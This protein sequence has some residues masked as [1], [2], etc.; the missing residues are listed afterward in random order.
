MT[1]RVGKWFML[2]CSIRGIFLK[3]PRMGQV[4][5]GRDEVAWHRSQ[6]E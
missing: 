6:R 3:M 4:W 5:V 1:I 2:A